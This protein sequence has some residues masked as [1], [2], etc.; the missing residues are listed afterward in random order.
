VGAEA[1]L[2]I[3][4]DE[5]GLRE[6]L[7]IL[8]RRAGYTVE[9]RAGVKAALATIEE[10]APFDVIVT[11]LLMPDGSGMTVLDEARKKDESTQVVMITAYATTEQAVHAMRMGAYDYVQKPFRNEGLRA[12]VEKA[13]EKRALLD[14]NRVLR[15]EASGGARVGEL[16][17]RSSALRAV[18]ELV[19]RVADA[20]TSVLITGESGTGK[21]MVARALHDESGRRNAPFVAVNCGALPES[22]MESEL[23]GHEKG[24]FTGATQSEEGLFRAAAGGTLFLDEVGELPANLQVKLLRVLQDRRVRPVGGKTEI[25][26]DV[27]VVAATNRDI[28]QAVAEGTFRQ[29][30]F[31]RLNVIHISLPALRERPEDVPLLAEHFLRK[32]AALHRKRLSWSP[33]AMHALARYDFPGNVRELENL[34]ERA[35][36]LTDGPDVREDDVFPPNRRHSLP[37]PT[38]AIDIPEEGLDL[39]AYLADIERR[40]L[41]QA[42]VRS[43]GVRK[44]AAVLLKTTFRSLRYRLAKYG[45]HGSDEPD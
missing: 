11:D 37:T 5:N 39:D 29:D 10:S 9:A 6:M 26:V 2:L 45:L 43:G 36:T 17:G 14:E 41:L 30:L 34:V 7:G 15:A 22:L 20:P 8:F 4:E 38:T 3:V 33:G 42:L 19:R 13:I 12:T 24:S 23:F 16:V 1:R 27:R 32:H 35:V 44:Q 18:M 31:Y 25:E 21:E 28:E 40:I